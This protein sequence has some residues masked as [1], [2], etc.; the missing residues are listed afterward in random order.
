[1]TAEYSSSLGTIDGHVVTV[2]VGLV[3]LR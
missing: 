1:M 2:S 3:R